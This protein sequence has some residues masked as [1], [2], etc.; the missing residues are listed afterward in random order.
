[1]DAEIRPEPSAEERKAILAAL[2]REEPD[3]PDARGAWWRLG[4]EESLAGMQREPES[5]G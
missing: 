1:V 2:A 4:I 5:T 3:E